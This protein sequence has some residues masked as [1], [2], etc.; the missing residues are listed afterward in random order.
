MHA[1]VKLNGVLVLKVQRKDRNCT[2]SHGDVTGLQNHLVWKG[3]PE[4]I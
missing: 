1:S 4:M 2:G 3:P